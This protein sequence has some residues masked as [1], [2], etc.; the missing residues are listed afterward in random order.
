MTIVPSAACLPSGVALWISDAAG[1]LVYKNNALLELVAP[2]E[3]GA[4]NWVEVVHPDMREHASRQYLEALCERTPFSFPVQTLLANG[5]YGWLE[6]AG[7]PYYSE[8]GS[9]AGMIGTLKHIQ[10]PQDATLPSYD[11]PRFSCLYN[12]RDHPL[13]KPTVAFMVDGV[14]ANTV[15]YVLDLLATFGHRGYHGITDW[16]DMATPLLPLQCKSCTGEPQDD[17][18]RRA[19]QIMM[20]TP[21]SWLAV[22]PFEDAGVRGIAE[23]MYQGDFIGYFVASRFFLNARESISDPRYLTGA[24]LREQAGCPFESYGILADVCYGAIPGSLD[25]LGVD[26][27]LTDD[28]DLLLQARLLG[29]QAYLQDRPWNRAANISMRVAS[30][31]EFLARTVRVN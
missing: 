20:R 31:A 13:R 16:H 15:Q 10:G 19:M 6:S 28:P 4:M 25:R 30:P 3:S 18:K 11:P 27:L 29:V 24:W 22:E 5:E 12:R 8:D 17:L 9:F 23:A 21:D 1:R 2:Y 14:L 7:R 26:F